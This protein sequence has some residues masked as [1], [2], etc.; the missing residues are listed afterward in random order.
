MKKL[1][2]FIA[3]LGLSTSK[4]SA[5]GP[6]TNVQVTK[7]TIH[8]APSHALNGAEF[9]KNGYPDYY[10]VFSYRNRDMYLT[11]YKEECRDFPL[12]YDLLKPFVVRNLDLP[13]QFSLMDYDVL[14][15]NEIVYVF[16]DIVFAD[17]KDYPN[18]ISLKAPD[19]S[20]E[21]SF[22]LQWYNR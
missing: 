21:V 5:Q 3:L 4:V 12:N 18:E 14:G 2:V 16:K 9:D 22:K 6:Y 15:E 7:V 8:K 11:N 20:T 17:Y 10:G 13:F 1:L 19:G